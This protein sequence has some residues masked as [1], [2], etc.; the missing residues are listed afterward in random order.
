MNNISEKDWIGLGIAGGVV[1][2][3]GIVALLFNKKSESNIESKWSH[4]EEKIHWVYYPNSLN[5]LV[6]KAVVEKIQRNVIERVKNDVKQIILHHKISNTYYI[7][8]HS[9]LVLSLISRPC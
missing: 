8:Y 5:F 2:I 3:G 7:F 4:E 9:F 1:V 6:K